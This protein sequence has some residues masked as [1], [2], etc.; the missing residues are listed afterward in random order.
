MVSIDTIVSTETIAQL[1]RTGL[2]VSILRIEGNSTTEPAM[3]TLLS[4]HAYGRVLLHIVAMIA[5]G[6]IRWHCAGIA[7]ELLP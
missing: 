7:R 4:Q 5:D 2:R 1:P 3:E 6:H